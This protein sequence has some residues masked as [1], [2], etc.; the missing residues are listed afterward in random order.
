MASVGVSDYLFAYA[1]PS[2]ETEQW[3]AAHAAWYEALGGVP[4]ITTSDNLKAAVLQPGPEPKLM[5]DRYPTAS[6]L[7][8]TSGRPS[9]A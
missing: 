2:Q 8:T 1:V 4:A 5:E 7:I 3:I 6:V 9:P